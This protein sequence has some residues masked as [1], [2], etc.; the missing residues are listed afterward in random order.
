MRS[1][2]PS[3]A[4]P[5]NALPFPRRRRVSDGATTRLTRQRPSPSPLRRR[6]SGETRPRRR[7]PR[8]SS[9]NV[10]VAQRDRDIRVRRDS[11]R[12]TVGAVRARQVS[13]PRRKTPAAA[14]VVARR[15]ITAPARVSRVFCSVI[16]PRPSMNGTTRGCPAG[17]TRFDPGA[18]GIQSRASRWRRRLRAGD[19]RDDVSPRPPSPAPSDR[20]VEPRDGRASISMTSTWSSMPSAVSTAK[21]RSRAVGAPSSTPRSH[22]TLPG[23][24]FGT[25]Q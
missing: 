19:A 23:R 15:N 12:A 10:P 22:T 4:A 14:E 21:S 17:A 3:A 18:A 1:A 11:H 16:L 24:V 20:E 7:R 6:R 13:P 9:R 25:W 2:S 8:L 5:P